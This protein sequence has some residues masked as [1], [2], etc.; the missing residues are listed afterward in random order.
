ML[1][2]ATHLAT[3]L[4]EAGVRDYVVIFLPIGCLVIRN[5][6]HHAVALVPNIILC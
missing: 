1:Q 5:P 6:E 3:S 2:K 4:I